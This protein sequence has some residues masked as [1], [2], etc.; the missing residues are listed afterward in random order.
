MAAGHTAHDSSSSSSSLLGQAC[1]GADGATA[2]GDTSAAAGGN[3]GDG[4][5]THALRAAARARAT[6]AKVWPGLPG[7]AHAIVSLEGGAQ[8]LPARAAAAAAAHCVAVGASVTASLQPGA[9]ARAAALQAVMLRKPAPTASGVDGN[10]AGRVVDPSGEDSDVAASALS[11]AA[12]ASAVL[13]AAGR[14]GRVR[15][16]APSGA[17]RQGA[18]AFDL[19][20]QFVVNTLRDGRHG[21]VPVFVVVEDFDIFA[22]RTKQTLLYNLLDLT[23]SARVHLA[24]VGLTTRLDVL[25]VRRAFLLGRVQ[26]STAERAQAELRLRAPAATNLRP[27][28]NPLLP[29]HFFR[30][31]SLRSACARGFL[32]A[33]C[34]LRTRARLACAR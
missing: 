30:T 24:L 11:R 27:L 19:H 18:N 8:A 6:T 1:S 5:A 12:L 26:A 4:V 33:R 14:A 34:S 15:T 17:I 16:R 23:Q 9:A 13:P 22:R 3:V 10:R 29:T 32:T 28:P 20:L 31:S 2:G 25:Q 21:G 7:F